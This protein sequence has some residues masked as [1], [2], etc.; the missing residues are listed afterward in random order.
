MKALINQ[1]K[2]HWI[3]W[4]IGVLFYPLISLPVRLLY[5]Y[6]NKL[7]TSELIKSDTT[8]SKILW[9]LGAVL[10][11]LILSVGLENISMYALNRFYIATVTDIQ[12]EVYRKLVSSSFKQVNNFESG[13]LIT[14][15]NTD[16][17]IAANLVSWDIMSVIYPLVF[18]IGYLVSFFLTNLIIGLSM[19]TIEIIV[20]LLNFFYIKRGKFINNK[21]LT[22]KEGLTQIYGSSIQGKMSIRQ[23]SAGKTVEAMIRNKTEKMYKSEE[24][25]VSLDTLKASTLGVFVNLCSTMMIPFACV[26]SVQGLINLPSV[27]LIA[28][29]S[30][31]FLTYTSGLGIALTS[32]GIH[33]VSYSRLNSIF[34]WPTESTKG[35]DSVIANSSQKLL[36]LDGVSIAYGNNIVLKEANLSINSG[37]IIVL[38]GQSGSGKSSIIKALLRLINYS[39]S[40]K[41]WGKDIQEYKLDQ[42]RHNISY[43]PELNNL[44]DV[45]VLQN[46][47]YANPNANLKQ[48]DEAF[49]NAAIG[50]DDIINIQVGEN[51]DRLS[52][53][54]QQRVAIARA[55]IKDAPILIMDEPTAS[56]DTISEKR[57][58]Q[59]FKELKAKGKCLIIITH[60]KSTMEIA[61]NIIMIK[62]KKF[63]N[64][65]PLNEVMSLIQQDK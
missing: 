20:I 26:L 42:L 60:R 37:E 25:L 47:L 16:S 56:L 4:V 34:K 45:T 65:V 22:C 64:S 38:V 5:A 11:G 28:Q 12:Q 32:F 23:L 9:I 53:G 7:Y 43:V 39:G 59:T 41:L 46:V 49:Q 10:I 50:D 48:I 1:I 19:L 31:D 30:R 2:K 27:I 62:D 3:L 24:E 36:E 55:L 29:L 17:S 44:F 15:Y 63:I 33:S 18:G 58:L 14:R 21:L 51:G 35:K 8:L 57:V 52:G 40:I 54:Q 6:G 13:E 61:D